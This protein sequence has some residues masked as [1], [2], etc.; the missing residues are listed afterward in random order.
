M[1]HALTL[2]D[3][4]LHIPSCVQWASKCTILAWPPTA[5]SALISFINMECSN[6]GALSVV[7]MTSIMI[8]SAWHTMHDD[9]SHSDFAN[10]VQVTLILLYHN[11]SACFTSF[12]FLHCSNIHFM[13]R[14]RVK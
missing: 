9:S 4:M 13:E 2:S 11:L 12:Q 10:L 7:E 8:T 6:A 3:I 1:K 14:T 5:F